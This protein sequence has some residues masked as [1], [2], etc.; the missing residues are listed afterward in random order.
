MLVGAITIS[1]DVAP[2]VN[3]TSVGLTAASETESPT[4]I[5]RRATVNASDAPVPPTANSKVWLVI[6]LTV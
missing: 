3:S 5:L 1:C 6:P 2:V 4:L